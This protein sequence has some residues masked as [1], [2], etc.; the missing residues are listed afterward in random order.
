[1]GAINTLGRKLR[2]GVI[3]GGLGSF[4]GPV[5]RGAAVFH[6]QYEVVASVLSSDPERSVSSGQQIGIPRPYASADE[7]FAAEKDHPERIDLLAIMTPNNS[8]YELACQAMDCGI[9]VFCEK[10]LTN[11]LAEA[12]DLAQRAQQQDRLFG[13]AY[14]YTGYPMV[15]QARAM[16]ESGVLGELRMVQ[17]E[18]IQGHLATLTQSEQDGTNWHMEPEVAGP[19]L[20]L[21]DIATHSYHLAAYITGQEPEA[22]SADVTTLTPGRDAH[23]YCGIL[24]RYANK[25]RGVFTVTQAAAGAV[26]GLRIRVFGS[27][28]GLEWFQE[29]PD[30]LI[31]RPMD[32]P[33]QRLLRGGAGL[34]EAANRATHIA[35]GH[36]EGYVEAFAN[37][38]QDMADHMIAR[39]QGVEVDPLALWYPGI[40]DGVRGV[41]F[42]ETALRS[43]QQNAAWQSLTEA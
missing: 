23:D 19:S 13:V 39:E 35:M 41:A 37:L 36:P 34:S 18:Y 24:S 25:A 12:K 5:H 29:Q 1:M 27:K 4:I 32:A 22:L 3:G 8:H 26:H 40:E 43:S 14:A 31:Y 10:P 38:Y 30:E 2:L 15:R 6:E 7:L 9:D 11:D 33:E 42:V 21:G 17:S 20:I 28:G 16:M